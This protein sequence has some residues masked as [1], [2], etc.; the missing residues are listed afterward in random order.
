MAQQEHRGDTVLTGD[1]I[2][3][4]NSEW[5]GWGVEVGRVGSGGEWE[6]SG[7]GSAWEES[8]CVH[9]RCVCIAFLLALNGSVIRISEYNCVCTCL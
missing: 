8:V 5:E 3:T 4:V 1:G 2:S 6:W 7:S 9:A